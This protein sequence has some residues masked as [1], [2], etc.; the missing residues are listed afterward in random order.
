[1]SVPVTPVLSDL[2]KDLL[3][4]SMPNPAEIICVNNYTC[5][6]VMEMS[7]RN[8]IVIREANEE[9]LF[10]FI[11]KAIKLVPKNRLIV[12]YY[13]ENL[14]NEGLTKEEQDVRNLHFIKTRNALRKLGFRTRGKFLNGNTGHDVAMMICYKDV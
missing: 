12:F 4:K 6:G 13:P 1:M 8:S 5:C 11:M 14:N 9:T 10:I 3:K 2:A 7:I